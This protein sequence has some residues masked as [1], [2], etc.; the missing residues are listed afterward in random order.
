LTAVDTLDAPVSS[1]YPDQ[2][3]STS[4]E[5]IYP[6]TDAAS[7]NRLPHPILSDPALLSGQQ[8]RKDIAF[9]DQVNRMEWEVERE[10]EAHRIVAGL[11][12]RDF[13]ALLRSFDKVSCFGLFDMADR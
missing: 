6:L 9:D 13:Y 3:F 2:G 12:T 5:A 4:N 10:R 7:P 1:A 8:Q 11:D